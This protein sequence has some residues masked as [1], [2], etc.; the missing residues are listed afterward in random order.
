VRRP[1]PHIRVKLIH[2]LFSVPDFQKWKSQIESQ[3]KSSYVLMKGACTKG[4]VMV[5]YFRCHRSGSA[6]SYATERLP[7]S[8]GS[9]KMG[10]TCPAIMHVVQK[11]GSSGS[12]SVKHVSTHVGHKDEYCFMNL[13]KQERTQIAMKLKAGVEIQRILDDVRDSVTNEQ[14]PTRIHFLTRQDIHNIR[15]DFQLDVEKRHQDDSTSVALWVDQMRQLGD[16][17]PVLF[18]K[19]QDQTS[20]KYPELRAEDYVLVIMTSGQRH[21]AAELIND[22]FC[23]DSTHSTNGY[24]SYFS[25]LHSAATLCTN[26]V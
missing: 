18:Y 19:P 20:M 3:E 15:R 7:P 11:L 21:V 2:S 12:I 4:D 24:D 9:C 22:R 1:S 17:N 8:K 5:R 14:Q 25:G 26:L 23:V 10:K 13:S 16:H 6:V